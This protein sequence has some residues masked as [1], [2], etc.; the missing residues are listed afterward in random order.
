VGIYSTNPPAECEYI[1]NHSESTFLVVE[2]EEQ[3]DKALR[4]KDNLQF[5][6]YIIVIDTRYIKDL[7]DP[8]IV[9]FD[10]VIRRG[11]EIDRRNPD[12]FH[13]LINKICPDD[14]A[15]IVYTSGTTG[16]PKG[17]MI[18]HKN[19]ISAAQAF[20][21]GLDVVESDE[22]LSYLPLSHVAERI[23]SVFLAILVGYTV[24]FAESI[25]TV[26]ENLKEISP[27]WLV[28]PPRIWEK[29]HSRITYEIEETTWLKRKAFKWG[30]YWGEK[31][32]D[33]IS[34]GERISIPIK[35]RHFIARLFIYRKIKKLLGLE[36][37]RSLYSGT[38]P[39]SPDI[40]HFFRSLD[41]DI[42][43]A[44]G[45]T[46]STG[47]G[48]C[49]RKGYFRPG[50]VGQPYPGV[51][52]K[53]LDDGEVLL[54]GDFVFKGYL[55]DQAGTQEAICDGWLHTG[56]VGEVDN[57]GYLRIT[58]RKKDI[59]I[60][61]GGKNISP[62]WIENQLKY[63]PFIE[64]ALVIGDRRKYLVALIV[65]DEENTQR[66][67]QSKR[68]PFATYED[69]AKQPEIRN[70]IGREI[71]KV[72]QNLSRAE[73]IKRFTIFTNRLKQDENELT[74][75][76]KIRRKYVSEKYREIIESLYQ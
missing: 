24:N 23:V 46:E 62:Q 54:K 15:T 36:R 30:L 10:E 11:M 1:L 29:F 74:P 21:D 71:E 12:H 52:L 18:T 2:D 63:S 76:M 68:I 37:S 8:M 38:A 39:I 75:T 41:L 59:I 53:V 43:E 51:S 6:R 57:E 16:P 58:D 55:N 56:D 25:E 19:I 35:I 7:D 4:I 9:S 45:Q 72:N 60:T 48:T 70:L 33:L 3:L 13:D 69:L 49:H 40:L 61:S 5:L 31:W 64:D 27:T 50:T 42:R 65:I 28:C 26:S 22:I 34:K 17:V 20:R 44:Y 32:V 67:A 73:R 47:V 14:V 66:Y